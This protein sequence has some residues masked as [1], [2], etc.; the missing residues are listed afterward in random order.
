MEKNSCVKVKYKKPTTFYKGQSD[1]YKSIKFFLKKVTRTPQ[2]AGGGIVR[3]ENT[4]M[5]FFRKFHQFFM[6]DFLHT[7]IPMR[8]RIWGMSRAAKIFNLPIFIPKV[9][10]FHMKSHAEI[11]LH[12]Q[13]NHNCE[14]FNERSSVMMLQQ[15]TKALLPK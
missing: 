12:S 9:Y 15:T 3:L 14:C 8:R 10:I 1:W 7:I 13:D 2:S 11:Y 5:Q 6:T 4:V